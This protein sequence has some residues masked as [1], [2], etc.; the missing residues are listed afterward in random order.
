M[1]ENLQQMLANG[2]D[3]LLLRFGLGQALLKAG[4]AD[5]AIVHL[6]RALDHD[7]RHSAAWKLLGKAYAETG[8]H[9][10]ATETYQR[11][12]AIAQEKGDMQAVK[13]MQVFLKRLQKQ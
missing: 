2:R 5:E 9:E 3:D 4:R 13:E 1:I 10:Q 12:I 7:T 8:Q 6:K 11:G